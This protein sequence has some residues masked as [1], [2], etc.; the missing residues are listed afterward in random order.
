[1]GDYSRDC[2][3]K[4]VCAS[5]LVIF[6]GSHTGGLT[7]VRWN[8]PP[9]DAQVIHIDID[10]E[11]IGRNYPHTLGLWGDAKTVLSQLVA[12]SASCANRDA[13]ME[14]IGEL[15]C[16]WQKARAIHEESAAV[17]I[18]PERLCHDISELLPR[19]AVV[20]GDTG[21]AGMWIA[22]HF[23]TQH[24]GQ[25]FMRAAG[26]LGWGLPAAIGAKC[27]LPQR[28]VICFA[29]DGG[30][31]IHMAE[32]ETAVRYSINVIVIVNNNQALSQEEVLWRDNPAWDKNWKLAPVDIARLAESMG[33]RGIRVAQPDQISPALREAF[34]AQRPVVIELLTD[35]NCTAALSWIP[36]TVA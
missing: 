32:L 29:G 20:V 18:R 33:C 25:R 3:N 15:K 12:A 36:S 1:V 4:A 21:H 28:P 16:G 27:A 34:S 30:F 13:W 7:T 2:A 14:R 10:P 23:Y 31:M 24:V 19:D 9:R 8:V 35:V 17:P 6:I 22:Q 26:S 5:D 11:V